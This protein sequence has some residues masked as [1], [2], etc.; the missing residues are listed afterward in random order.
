[1]RGDLDMAPGKL[2]SQAT[3]ASRISLLHFLKRHPDRID[4]FI[5]LNSCGSVVVL[6]AKN[7]GQLERARD[8]AEA[9]G[10]PTALFADREH[11]I[12]GTAF[13]GSPVV[14]A[15]AIGP[16]TREAM[17]EITKRFRCA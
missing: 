5:D 15:L 8:Q 14:T 13:D 9:A 2:A 11:V 12:P 16:A 6:K 4:E 7:L 3:H 1:M 10:L 17:R